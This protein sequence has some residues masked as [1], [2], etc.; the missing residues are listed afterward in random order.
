MYNAVK[1]YTIVDDVLKA[2][3]HEFDPQQK[4]NDPRL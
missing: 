3:G 2:R 4:M 1:L